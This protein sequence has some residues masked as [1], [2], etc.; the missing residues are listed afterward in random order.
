MDISSSSSINVSGI[1]HDAD[2]FL[3]MPVE[4]PNSDALAI[5]RRR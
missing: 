5:K 2:S 1:S 4:S 3:T